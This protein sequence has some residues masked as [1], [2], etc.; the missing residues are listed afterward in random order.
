MKVILD[1]KDKNA[2]FVMELLKNLP[3]VKTKELTNEKA[4]ILE[5]LAEAVNEVKLAKQGKIKLKN[6]DQLLNEL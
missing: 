4:R 3:F 2:P 1:I 5:N 6:L